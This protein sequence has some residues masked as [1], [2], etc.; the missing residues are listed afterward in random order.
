M[1]L[2]II[3]VKDSEILNEALAEWTKT[4]VDRQNE[5]RYN[6]KPSKS[7]SVQYQEDEIPYAD[8][9]SIY[10]RDQEGR[11]A[12]HCIAENK[13]IDQFQVVI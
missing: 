11:N 2:Q 5:N 13:S 12:M 4:L 7:A 1:L 8:Y 9:L 3:K 6:V 10:Q